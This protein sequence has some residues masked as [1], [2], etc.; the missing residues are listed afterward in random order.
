MTNSTGSSLGVAVITGASSG[1]GKAFAERLA[2]DGYDIVL[3]ARRRDRLESVAREIKAAGASAEII[4]ADLAQSHGLDM[5]EQRIQAGDVSLLVNNAG[6]QTYMPFVDLS[7][8]R[9]QEEV[10]VQVTA[11]MRL[12]H[13]ALPA[14][15][16]RGEGAIIN[17]SSLLCFSGS[18]KSPFM[19]KRSVYAATK[20]FITMFS[21]LLAAELQGKGILVQALC[22]AVVRTEFHDIDGKPVLRPNV[23]VMEPGD[24]VNAS[25]AG[26]RQG[27]TICIPALEQVGKLSAV[28]DANRALFDAGRGAELAPR[29]R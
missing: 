16:A 4:V 14:M 21:E 17:V 28:G 1:I 25:L 20:A 15:I 5:V 18:L 6:F 3:V 24:V 27:D 19:P 12:S 23:P 11:V 29:Y 2:S 13:A 10:A 7:I 26:L 8:D 9:A 22:P